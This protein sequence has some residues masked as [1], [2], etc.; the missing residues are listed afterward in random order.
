MDFVC[1][2]SAIIDIMKVLQVCIWIK[3][4]TLWIS[5]NKMT[6]EIMKE[7]NNIKLLTESEGT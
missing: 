6:V 1:K 3:Y 5:Y 7:K 4:D 2:I